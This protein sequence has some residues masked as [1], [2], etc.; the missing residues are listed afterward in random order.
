MNW[1]GMLAMACGLL[2][3]P[4]AGAEWMRA[5]TP[6]FVV[7]E[8]AGADEIRRLAADLERFDGFIRLFH[9]KADA[10]GASSNK[11][12]VYVLSDVSAVQRLCGKCAN[13]YGFYNGRASGSVA[14]TPRHADAGYPGAL[15]GRTVL[16]HE[17]GHHFLLGN[18]A[19]AYPAWFSEGYAEF[20]ST[21]AIKDKVTIGV[22]AQHRGYGLIRGPNMPATLLFDPGSRKKLNS[23]QVDVLYGRGW[24]LTHWIM[25]DNSRRAMFQ[26]YLTLLNAGTP[27]VKAATEA[28]GDLK[29]LDKTLDAYLRQNRLPGI[30]LPVSQVPEP[31]VAVSPVSEGAAAMMP[32]RLASTRGV[33]GDTATPLFRKA[34]AT[35][36][37]YPADALAQGW[38]AEIAF[39]AGEPAAAEAA[40]DR[41][42][43]ADPRSAQALIYKAL[44]AMAGAEKDAAKW[45]AARSLIIRANKLDPNYAYPLVLFYVSFER[46]ERPPTASAI[47]GL[48]RALELVPQD[49]GVRFMAARQLIRDGSL[50]AAKVALAPLAYHPHAPADNPAIRAIAA[51]DKG[52]GAAALAAFEAKAEDKAT[53]PKRE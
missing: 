19:V 10:D 23:A 47:A 40:A 9:D 28:F 4:S 16:F 32:F 36:A 14:F 2:L 38:F 17:Y 31:K 6:H 44:V 45:K 24:L 50:P 29:K 12:T 13:V 11:L 3:A 43:A 15:G 49:D 1:R 5:E 52:D 21:M 7:Y 35:A 51:L 33:N 41:A 25:F 42:L 37:R 53:A 34:Q 22:A 20:V 39:D 18:Y 27:S 26:R 46:E 30:V 8:D 48:Y